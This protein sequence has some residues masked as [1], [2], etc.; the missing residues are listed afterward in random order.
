MIPRTK[1]EKNLVV[2]VDKTFK[3]TS[4]QADKVLKQFQPKKIDYFL[5]HFMR[6]L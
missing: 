2:A 6:G 4:E 3:N 1:I 5:I